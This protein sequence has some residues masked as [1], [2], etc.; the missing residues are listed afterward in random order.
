MQYYSFI[1]TV[2]MLFIFSCNEP[3]TDKAANRKNAWS[4]KP[5]TREDSLYNEVMKDH[6]AG[7]ARMGKLSRAIRQ[8]TA[9]TDSL[10]RLKQHTATYKSVLDQLE[11]AESAMNTWMREFNIDS[12]KEDPAFRIPYLEKEKMKVAIVKENIFKS[13]E[14]A[15]SLFK[16]RK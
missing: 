16:G 8:L 4:D 1:P 14:K 6:D 2:L 12:L 9:A 5:A 3:S 7:M 10:S 11:N 15:D 13:L